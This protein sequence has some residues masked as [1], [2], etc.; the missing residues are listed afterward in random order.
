MKFPDMQLIQFGKFKGGQ[1]YPTNDLTVVVD[2]E[3]E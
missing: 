1:W 3:D 2:E